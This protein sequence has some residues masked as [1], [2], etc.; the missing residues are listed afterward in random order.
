MA[1]KRVIQY[2][3]HTLSSSDYE[4]TLP[5]NK[6]WE[7]IDIGVNATTAGGGAWVM[8]DGTSMVYIPGVNG[9]MEP[10][11]PPYVD[12]NMLGL[13]EQFQQRNESVASLRVAPGQKITVRDAVAGGTTTLYM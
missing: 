13:Y 12:G 3:K 6:G 9:F 8:I 10:G 1:L 2:L 7:I 11:A 4:F 5:F